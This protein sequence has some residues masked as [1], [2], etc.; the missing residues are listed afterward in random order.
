[1]SYSHLCT[2]PHV[3]STFHS[4]IRYLY[5]E[6]GN[7]QIRPGCYGSDHKGGDGLHRWGP[8]QR[9]RQSL[10]Q[11]PATGADVDGPGWPAAAAQDQCGSLLVPGEARSSLPPRGP[12][13]LT[14]A[15]RDRMAP[16]K[17]HCSWRRAAVPPAPSEEAYCAR[18][19]TMG[20]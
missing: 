13:W 10:G 1:M 18:H 19:C 14:S 12:W 4:P 17:Q 8:E 9:R 16:W 11:L 3:C 7:R 5:R 20:Y 15:S 6:R 2:L